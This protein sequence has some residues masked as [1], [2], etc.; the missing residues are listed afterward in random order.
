MPSR[1]PRL[2]SFR[3]ALIISCLLILTGVTQESQAEKLSTEEWNISA[4]KLINYDNPQSIVAKGNVILEKK[5]RKVLRPKQNKTRVSPWAE[6]LEEKVASPQIK[7]DEVSEKATA[8]LQATATIKAD[9]IVYDV[10]LESIKAKG[11][12]QIITADDQLRATEATIKLAD[13]TG[14]FT[15]ATIIR[16]RHSLHLEGKSIE[17]TGFD[18]YKI[19]DGWVITC[20]IKDGEVPPWS[21]SSSEVDIQPGGYAFLKHAKLNIRNIPVFYTPWLVVPVKNTRQTGFLFPE[22]SSSKNGGF[23]FNLPFFWNI[24]ESMDAT[25]FPEFY[26]NR[27]FMPGAEFRYVERATDKGMFAANYL[28][29]NLSD[30]SETDYYDDTGFTH[31]NSDRYWI[32]GKADHIFG[33]SWHSRLDID[34]VSDQ[35]YLTEFKS[36]S[37]GFK[38]NQDQY[39]DT[40]GRG[41]QTETDTLRKN[42]FK[43]LRSWDGIAFET[44][45]LAIN[46][47]ESDPGDINTPLW[48]LPSVDFTGAVP[49]WTSNFTLDWNADYVNYWREDGIGGNR[50]DLRPS[51]A[52]PIPLSPYLESRA[53][54]GIR[55]TF[56]TIQNYGGAN[57]DKDD[58]QNRF[59]TEFETEVATTLERDFFPG[60]ESLR[61]A[62]H[63][64]RPFIKYGYVQD[65]DQEDLPFFDDVDQ[66]DGRNAISYGIDNFINT[67]TYGKQSLERLREYAYL[68]IDQYYDLRSEASDEP[69]SD[70]YTQLGWRPTRKANLTYKSYYDVYDNNFASHILEGEYTNSRGDYFSVDYS[71]QPEDAIKQ[72]NAQLRARIFNKWF[73][74][75]SIKHSIEFD[76]TD[77]ASVFL[78][79]RALCW[80]VKF[81][82][83][84]TPADTTYLVLFDLA[85]IGTSLGMGL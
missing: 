58:T 47:A 75:G 70:I 54:L 74:G 38:K 15:D 77:E 28:D 33:N 52:A 63:Q 64:I 8:V 10:D 80:S 17:K 42:T 4:D 48:K 45:F 20:N 30:P 3:R 65:V 81:S 24:S 73:A 37:T 14:R 22:V 23:G 66:V 40:F 68:K 85:N 49:L 19:T 53:E 62:V 51:I 84:Y 83:E 11:N 43:I 6:L 27:G 67:F 61:S 50:I 78:T 9:W 29:D 69:F 41:F 26:T 25:F 59:L 18:T 72:I 16:K 46:E 1:P 82:T 21:F 39:L 34:V 36:G 56:Y 12:V 35:D 31:T 7:A 5:E 79:Y 55:D 60:G 57:W 76:Q 13:G 44:N 71:Y 32:R 2:H